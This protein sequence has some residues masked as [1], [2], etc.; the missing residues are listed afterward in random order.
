MNPPRPLTTAELIQLGAEASSPCAD[1]QT[2]ACPGWES[3]RGGAE[4]SQLACVGTLRDAALED[5]TVAEFHPAGTRGE[6]ADAPIAPGWF[7][8]NRCDVWRC[9]RCAS[10]F[11]RYT[12][13]GG[14]YNDE[15][16]RT[17]NP[18]LVVVS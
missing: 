9:T 7:P 5:P 3:V 2:L 17:L 1:C 11:L 6:S 13:Y 12:E 14:Y 4:L 10:A 18:A 16:I 15:R 8:Y